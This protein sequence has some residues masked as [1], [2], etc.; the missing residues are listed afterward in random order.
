MAVR[1]G[2]DKRWVLDRH[3]PLALIVTIVVQTF[4]AVWGASN[5]WARVG[6]LEREVATLTPKAERL[7]R[8]EEKLGSVQAT[9]AE[10]KALLRGARRSAVP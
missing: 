2:D 10:I 4:V 8:L 9:L 5:L 6:G 7:I 1:N 3:I